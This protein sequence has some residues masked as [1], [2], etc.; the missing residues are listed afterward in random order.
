MSCIRV[1][2]EKKTKQ[3]YKKKLY[4]GT[5]CFDAQNLG[6]T[7]NLLRVKLHS[8]SAP[9]YTDSVCTIN[10]S[11]YYYVYSLY[12]FRVFSSNASSHL[13]CLSRKY[14]RYIDTTWITVVWMPAWLSCFEIWT[15]YCC[16]PCVPC[17]S[18]NSSSVGRGKHCGNLGPN[19]RR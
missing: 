16:V 1:K 8:R 9:I 12:V 6:Q 5:V 11:S 7:F 13:F 19:E 10:T 14:N 15:L 4:F 2:R 18:V 17:F 3:N